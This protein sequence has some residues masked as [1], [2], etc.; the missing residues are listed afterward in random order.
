MNM[1]STTA[2]SYAANLAY[3][4]ALCA[5]EEQRQLAYSYAHLGYSRHCTALWAAE[6]SD[7]YSVS[8]AAE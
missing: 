3:A 8:F 7:S 1:S 6:Q 5:P 2:F 4:A